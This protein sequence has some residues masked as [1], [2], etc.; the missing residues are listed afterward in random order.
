[1]ATFLGIYFKYPDYNKVVSELQTAFNKKQWKVMSYSDGIN[2]LN[3]NKNINVFFGTIKENDEWISIAVPDMYI[4]PT[5]SPFI[6]IDEI[7]RI[8]KQLNCD[9]IIFSWQSISDYCYWCYIE[10]GSIRRIHSDMEEDDGDDSEFS[11]KI[12]DG[13][14]FAFESEIKNSDPYWQGTSE[15]EKK[16]TLTY[17]W[18]DA[19]CKKFGLN[20]K[21]IFLE[22]AWHIGID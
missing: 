15:E 12:N 16:N 10:S 13:I 7:L 19:Y 8:T 2:Y 17:E 5:L 4:S 18:A 20:I 3:N 9:C 11:V 14:P 21:N 22:M 1:M 6:S